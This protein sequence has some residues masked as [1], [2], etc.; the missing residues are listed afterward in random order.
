MFPQRQLCICICICICICTQKNSH[1][2]GFSLHEE[3]SSLANDLLDLLE[4]PGEGG[5]RSKTVP[6]QPMLEGSEKNV[7]QHLRKFHGGWQQLFLPGVSPSADAALELVEALGPC[8][9]NHRGELGTPEGYS[10]LG[11]WN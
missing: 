6:P 5:N 9:A 1:R 8:G 3:N 2:D 7:L 11:Y 4:K 10:R